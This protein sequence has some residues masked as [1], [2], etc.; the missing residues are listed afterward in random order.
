VRVEL[1]DEAAQLDAGPVRQPIVQD[2]NGNKV[3]RRL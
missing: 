3:G 1:A 2:V